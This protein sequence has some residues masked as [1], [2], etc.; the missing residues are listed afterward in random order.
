[1][2]SWHLLFYALS[3]L[4]LCLMLILY[5]LIRLS[6]FC[7]PFSLFLIFVYRF[8]VQ[9]SSVLFSSLWSICTR[10]SPY[11]RSTPSLRNFPQ[12]RLWHSS[13]VRLIDDGPLSPFQGRS[14]SASSFHASLLQAIA[15]IMSLAL[16]PHVACQAAQ[17]FRSSETEAACVYLFLTAFH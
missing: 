3:Y 2:H 9:F 11:M 7:P 17:H 8:S 13:N 4:C 12:R 15:D 1:M 5:L 6:K 10:K 14:S 16:C